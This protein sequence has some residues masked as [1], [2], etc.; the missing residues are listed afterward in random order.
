[1]IRPGSPARLGL[2]TIAAWMAAGEVARAAPLAAEGQLNGPFFWVRWAGALILC[3]GL[4]L[5]AAV[6]MKARQGRPTRGSKWPFMRWLADSRSPDRRLRLLETLRV[7]SHLE[8]SLLACDDEELL[9][10]STAQGAV[11]LKSR[12]TSR[13]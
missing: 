5:A 13:P 11:L 6:A 12:T 2:V 7:G 9:V 1:M 8:V 10:A 4:A 3:L